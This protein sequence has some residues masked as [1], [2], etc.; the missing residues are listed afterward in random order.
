DG[1][2]PANIEFRRCVF[3]K[4]TSWRNL[5]ESS[6][7]DTLNAKNLFE[8]KNVRRLYVEGSIFA[9]QWDAERSQFYAIA[10]KSTAGS[11]DGGYGSPWSV[12]EDIVFENNRLSHANGAF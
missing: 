8:T 12:S 7:G 5:P 3:T 2:V 1:L 9:N 11:P 10:L 6:F 4:R